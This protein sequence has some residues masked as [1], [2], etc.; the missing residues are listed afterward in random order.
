MKRN[1]SPLRQG[2]CRSQFREMIDELDGPLSRRAQ[3]EIQESDR[4][5][6]MDDVDLVR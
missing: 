2:R 5:M 4:E 1:T 6:G 3:S